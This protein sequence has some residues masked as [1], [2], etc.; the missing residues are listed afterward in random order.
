MYPLYTPKSGKHKLGK[1]I[2]L[3]NQFTHDLAMKKITLM[4]MQDTLTS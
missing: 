4:Y 1:H 2:S 3:L